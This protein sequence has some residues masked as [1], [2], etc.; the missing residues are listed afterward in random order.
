MLTTKKRRG[1]ALRFRLFGTPVR[2]G[3]GFPIAIVALPLIFG[4]QLGRSPALLGAWLGLVT[5]SVLVH[6][7]GHVLSLIHISEPTRPY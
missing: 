7:A 5:L 1:P 2:I 3:L 4:G 6:E